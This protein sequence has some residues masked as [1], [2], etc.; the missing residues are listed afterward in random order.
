MPVAAQSIEVRTSEGGGKAENISSI[1]V[2][3]RFNSPQPEQSTAPLVESPNAGTSEEKA[4]RVFGLGGV[5]PLLA[6][7]GA[8]ICKFD[9]ADQ[10][11]VTP[12]LGELVQSGFLSPESDCR[13]PEQVFLTPYTPCGD[14]PVTSSPVGL[15]PGGVFKSD[16][17]SSKVDSDHQQDEWEAEQGI[18]DTD[19]EDLCKRYIEQV[20][21]GHISDSDSS[22]YSSDDSDDECYRVFVGQESRESANKLACLGVLSGHKDEES[23]QFFRN[24]KS[25]LNQRM[26]DKQLPQS[27]MLWARGIHTQCLKDSTAY[28][29]VSRILDEG[30]LI[31][32]IMLELP[33]TKGEDGSKVCE[34]RA[35]CERFVTDLEST[36]R[37]LFLNG[38]YDSKVKLTEFRGLDPDTKAPF[39]T[40]LAMTDY[41]QLLVNNCVS[42]GVPGVHMSIESLKCLQYLDTHF[43]DKL[44]AQ[45]TQQLCVWGRK[46]DLIDIQ[47][48][49]IKMIGKKANDIWD[50]ARY[51]K[52]T[53]SEIQLGTEGSAKK[54]QPRAIVAQEKTVAKATR[55]QGTPVTKVQVSD[56]SSASQEQLHQAFLAGQASTSAGAGQQQ[57]GRHSGA[58]QSG[59]SST[60]AESGRSRGS[61]SKGPCTCCPH[62]T[63]NAA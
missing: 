41:Q 58:P 49:T 1:L 48:L 16:T 46:E 27:V 57:Q 59:T 5:F 39:K 43:E 28:N 21:A 52:S 60:R 55:H 19:T 33:D 38:Q 63:W 37:K 14:G 26:N 17:S 51:M 24:C 9:G 56:T 23:K 25:Y 54:Q 15:L 3:Q 30:T 8:A 12:A 40:P 11:G 4:P 2:G 47:S 20:F 35:R 44:G 6:D 50:L 18:S 62:S 10:G 13:G 22:G 34:N 7:P 29:E 53:L 45:V 32:R 31:A 61:A 42:D 36:C